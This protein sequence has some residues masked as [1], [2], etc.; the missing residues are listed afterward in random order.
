MR[1][2]TERIQP[3]SETPENHQ[4]NKH[5]QGAPIVRLRNLRTNDGERGGQ[6]GL[7]EPGATG[8]SSKIAGLGLVVPLPPPSVGAR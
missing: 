3:R 8:E 7:V 2:E 1:L 6:G 4:R 5:E